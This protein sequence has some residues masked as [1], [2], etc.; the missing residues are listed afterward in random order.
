MRRVNYSDAGGAYSAENLS[1]TSGDQLY[2]GFNTGYEFRRGG[3]RFGPTASLF[4][5]DGSIDGYSERAG[6]Q[7]DGAWLFDV[8]R[9]EYESLRLSVGVQADYAISTGFGVLI[10]NLRILHVTEAKENAEDIGLRLSNNPFGDMDLAT[11]RMFIE[12]QAV[13][14]QFLD[15]G[16]GV[17]GQFIM[18]FSGFFDYHFYESFKGFSRDGYS[19]GLRWDKPF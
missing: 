14:D 8:D 12:G 15:L 17:S 4:Y 19:F 2:V 7:T 5:I 11:E 6:M 18:G 10:P 1:D 3:W 9:Q 13:D 16:I